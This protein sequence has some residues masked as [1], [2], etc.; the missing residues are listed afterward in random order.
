[1]SGET[2]TVAG[3]R[4][5]TLRDAPA[6]RER[7]GWERRAVTID[8]RSGRTIEGTW[9]GVPVAPAVEAAGFPP[10]TTHLRAT[11]RDGHQVCVPVRTG[12]AGLLGFVCEHVDDGRDGKESDTAETPRLVA[13]DI[14]SAR[15]IRGLVRLEPAALPP[16]EDPRAHE[17]V[18]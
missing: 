14:D 16:G 13:P 10:E 7:V 1:M 3:D 4:E 11:A 9:S 6:V 2:V 8:C 17:T 5:L 18:G 15:A 12:L